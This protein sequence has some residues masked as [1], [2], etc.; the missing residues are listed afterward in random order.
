VLSWLFSEFLRRPR[1]HDVKKDPV[2]I[3]LRVGMV[4]FVLTTAFW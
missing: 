2:L 3:E 4:L 1:S